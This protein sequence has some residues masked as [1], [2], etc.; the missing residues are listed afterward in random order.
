LALRRRALWPSTLAFHQLRLFNCARKAARRSSETYGELAC[1]PYNNLSVGQ[2]TNL[3]T[4]KYVELLRDLFKEA[5]V[6]AK[7]GA[8]AIPLNHSLI[9]SAEVPEMDEKEL[10]GVI[11]I[12]ARK[13]VPVP[14]SE[15]ILDWWI[16][17]HGPSDFAQSTEASRRR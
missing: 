13:Y 8:I 10:A 3:P 4:D 7:V 2:A 5:N 16:V 15:V 12:E 14:I 1:G 11:P 17:P 9:V 6:T